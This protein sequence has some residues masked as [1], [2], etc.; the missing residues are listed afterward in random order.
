MQ[1]QSL[2]TDL[3]HQEHRLTRGPIQG[4]RQL[5]P[6]P[7]RLQ[8]FAHLALGPE[9]AVRRHGVVDALVWAEVVVVVDE[10]PQ[11]LLGLEELLRL[12][13]GPELG[14]HGAP[15][16]LALAQGLGVMGP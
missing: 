4:L 6:L 9:E 11:A 1:G 10:V 14:A 13:P 8:G 2:A 15:E 7:D 3:P 5:V 12:G 16:A